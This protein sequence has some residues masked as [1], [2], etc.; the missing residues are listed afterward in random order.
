[1]VDRLISVIIPTYRRPQML[2][3]AI[4]SVNKQDYAKIEII[5]VDDNS[6]DETSKIVEEFPDVVFLRNNTNE[7][8]GYSR[9]KGFEYS[10]GEYVVF[11]DDD[12]YYTEP[13]FFSR[14]VDVLRQKEDGTL[15]VADARVLDLDSGTYRNFDRKQYGWMSCNDYLRDFNTKQSSPLSTFTAMFSKRMLIKCG[16]ADMKMINDMSL[17]MRSLLSGHVYFMKAYIGV[18][19]VHSGSISKRITGQF[20]IANLEEKLA[21]YKIIVRRSL[22]DNYD[23]WWLNQMDV[24][25]SY[26]VYGS[27]PPLSDFKKVRKWCIANSVNLPE[28][29]EK[30]DKYQS[31]LIDYK[32][33]KLKS[34]I[35]GILGIK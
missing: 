2:R 30:L 33:C 31:Y 17:Y 10:H 32:I 16:I 34:K 27:I 3:E 12:D 20:V 1:M 5:V 13:T 22:F 25:V 9:K 18:Y 15:V 14:C 29:K 19:R 11:M 35:K 23:Q 21:V 4:Q 24:T 8:P 26:Y 7:G 6:W 28:V